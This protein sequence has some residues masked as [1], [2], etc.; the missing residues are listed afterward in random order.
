LFC[1]GYWD[2]SRLVPRFEGKRP[3]IPFVLVR[4]HDARRTVIVG[5]G[6]VGDG[7]LLSSG[8]SLPTIGQEFVD[9]ALR[10]AGGEL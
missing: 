7:E 1:G 10:P 6:D 8:D 9:P 4:Y 2:R 5:L 3:V